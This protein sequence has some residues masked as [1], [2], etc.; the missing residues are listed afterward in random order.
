MRNF[1][2][3]IHQISNLKR[4]P[5]CQSLMITSTNVAKN[6]EGFIYL[7]IYTFISNM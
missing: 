2:A 7:F 1:F 5:N 3:Q 4:I 6:I